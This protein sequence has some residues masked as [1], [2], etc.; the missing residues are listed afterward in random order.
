[1]TG[2]FARGK[3]RVH[4]KKVVV[5][6]S[7][8]L[9]FRSAFPKVLKAPTELGTAESDDG[10]GA[11]NGPVHSS[12]FETC[13]DGHLATG[14]YYSGGSTQ[15]LGVELRVAHPLSVGLK[16]VETATSLLGA[17]YLAPDRGE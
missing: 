7:C 8:G 2:R 11:V 15:A 16:I 1:L 6:A 5:H 17:G 9:S 12:A 4:P 10:V 13:A 14:F 3:V